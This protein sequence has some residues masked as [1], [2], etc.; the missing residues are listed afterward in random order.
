MP[1]PGPERE[2]RAEVIFLVNGV[3]VAIVENK[4]AERR[5][6]LTGAITQPRRY[7]AETPELA[8]M[9]Q[10]FNAPT[11]SS[12]ITA[13]L[14]SGALATCWSGG[15]GQ[16]RSWLSFTNYFTYESPTTAGSSGR[17]FAYTCLAGTHKNPA[18]D[19]A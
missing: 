1:T 2:P 6:A 14:D 8:V 17:T 11:S 15:R 10:V 5:N 16:C 7:Q 4:N 13:A 3:P 9:P 12:T 18:C 19:I